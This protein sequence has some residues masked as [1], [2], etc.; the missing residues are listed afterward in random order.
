M[1]TNTLK[2]YGQPLVYRLLNPLIMLLVRLNVSPNTITTIGFLLNIGVAVIF[3]V[4]AGAERTNL[5]YLGWGG[6][7]ILF[8]GLFD[9]IDGRL[10]RLSNRT[11]KFG[12]L[13]D[14][15]LDR[16]SE[17][18]MFLGI[19]YYLV[20]QSYFLSSLF[21]FIAMIGSIMVSYV[22][23]RAEGLGIACSDGLMQRPERILTISIS[24][25]L[26]SAISQFTG[27]FKFTFPNSGFPLF[28]NISIFVWP[29]F[30]LAI[31]TNYTAIDRLVSSKKALQN[32]ET[33]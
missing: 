31:L 22:R 12:A 13:Y 27:T 9:M 30:A 26:C 33:Q 10:A 4:G 29:L 6:T 21:A 19:T 16:Y 25:I 2:Q 23:A 7:M 24:A 8:A 18:V 17:L 15:V 28:E 32:Q 1:S 11:S 5:S 20:A 14:S 3:V